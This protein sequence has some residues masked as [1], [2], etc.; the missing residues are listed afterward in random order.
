MAV[1]GRMVWRAWTAVCRYGERHV[2]DGRVQ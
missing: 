2:S 1:A